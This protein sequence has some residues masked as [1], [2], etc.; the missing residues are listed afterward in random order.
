MFGAYP[1]AFKLNFS[2][3]DG[4]QSSYGHVFRDPWFFFTH[5]VYISTSNMYFQQ[6]GEPETQVRNNV[7]EL[8]PLFATRNILVRKEVEAFPLDS[9]V[10]DCGGILGLFLGFNFLMVW[11]WLLNGIIAILNRF[12][13]CR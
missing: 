8:C 10:A 11:E 6:S 12:N 7:S 3:S 13:I 1:A 4:F 9:L 5:P 2:L